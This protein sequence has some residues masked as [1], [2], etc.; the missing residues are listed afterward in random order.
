[1]SDRIRALLFDFDGLLVDTEEPVY[2]TWRQDYADHG[3]ELTLGTWSACIGTLD[4]FD[5]LEDLAARVGE[6]FDREAFLVRHRARRDALLAA[7]DLRPGVRDHLDG[8]RA[9][10]MRLAIVSSSGETWILDHLRR[11]GEDEGW[12]AVCA[13][14]GDP[15]RSKPA[16][17]LYLEAL[18]TLGARPDEAV[19]FEDSPNG[20]LAAKRAGLFCVAVPNA[21]TA[22]LDLSGADLV[23][24]SLADLPLG[25][26]LAAIA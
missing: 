1:M 15:A 5:P 10:G 22:A 16:P 17:T 12:D 13:A 19:A 23:V 4:G 26:L 7:T 24:D 25:D 14:N 2:R 3:F 11:L 18:R 21:V 20:I 8:A 6:T 9:A